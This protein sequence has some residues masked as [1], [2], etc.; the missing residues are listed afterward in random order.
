MVVD[1]AAFDMRGREYEQAI[2]RDESKY[3]IVPKGAQLGLTTIFIVKSMHSLVRRRWKVLYLLPLKAGSVAFVQGRIDPIIDHV[4]RLKA[5]FKRVDNRAQK[6]TTTG[7]NWYIRGT[8]IETELREVPADILVL[9]E[10]DKMNED[11]MPHAFERLAGSRIQRVYELSTPTIDGFGVYRDNGYPST[12]RMKWWVPCPYCGSKQV[13]TFEEN[14]QPYLGDTIEDCEESCRCSH[15]HHVLTDTDRANM[16]AGGVWV[17]E[18]PGGKTRGYHLNQLNSPTKSLADPQLGILVNYFLGQFDSKKLKEFHNLGL[19]LPYA[20]PGDKFTTELMDS[21]RRAYNHGSIPSTSLFLGIDQGAEVLHVTFSTLS[22]T[23]D[24][25]IIDTRLVRADGVRTKWQ[26]LDEDILQVYGNWLAVCDAHPDKEDCENL[27]KKYPGRFFMGFEKDRPEQPLTADYRPFKYG[28][29]AK[30]NIDRT[31]AFDSLIKSYLDGKTHLPRD[32]REMGE[33]MPKLAYNGFYHQHL[34]MVRVE[35]PDA[36]DRMVA[37]WVNGNEE[38][39]GTKKSGS[40]KRPDHWHHS[41]MFNLIATFKDMPL[42]V[43]PAVG[44]LFRQAG[45]LIGGAAQ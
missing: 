17:P 3:I 24:R 10:R 31:M 25:R 20:A 35:Q 29:P 37:R 4:P 19:G 7:I 1:G 33:Y 13:L 28:Q 23:N 34:Q 14:V 44:D 38:T 22:D 32:A 9:D 30:V 8:N 16:N 43:A 12:D 18:N 11:N 15:C 45:G 36:A 42:R 6:Q 41:D 2:L 5:E 21:C 39:A 27:S 26:V 40:G